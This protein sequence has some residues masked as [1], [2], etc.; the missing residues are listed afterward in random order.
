MAERTRMRSDRVVK[1][2]RQALRSQG[3]LPPEHQERTLADQYRQ[4]K[5]PLI[6]NAIGRGG[7][8]KLPRGQLIMVASAM[9]GEGKT[10]TSVNLA[11]SLALEKDLSVLL[12][13][14]DAPKPHLNR[15]LG[16]AGEPGL[17][18]LLRDESLDPETLIIPTDVP[19]LAMLPIGTSSETTTELL[20][21][22]RMEEIMKQLA[23]NN[24]RRIIVIDSPPLLLTSE[25]RV[26]AEV[27]GQVVLVVRANCTPQQSVL[28]AI[29]HLGEDKSIGLLLNQSTDAASAGY[30]YGYGDSK[31]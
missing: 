19:T 1:I 20:A 8:E 22:H 26:L 16:V 25:S 13:D 31:T 29:S 11:L 5:R 17:L 27:A 3:L 2:D 18:E 10:F 14:A 7:A 6:A 9:P 28:D 15:A 21:S 30:Y 4:I 12:I 23:G 24:P